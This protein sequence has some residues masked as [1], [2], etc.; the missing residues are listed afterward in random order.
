MQNQQIDYN[1][2]LSDFIQV[3]MRIL[4]ADIVLP[5]ARDVGIY[6]DDNGVISK[7][8]DDPKI[9]LDKLINELT[10]F[11]PFT[12]N[13]IINELLSEDDNQSRDNDNSQNPIMPSIEASLRS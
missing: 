9:A 11:S 7:I 8:D 6:T 3:Q 1:L 5:K 12:T 2:I 13:K 10:I 4:G